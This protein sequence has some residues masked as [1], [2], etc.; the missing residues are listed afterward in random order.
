MTPTVPGHATGTAPHAA[1]AP[2]APLP[3]PPTPA[4]QLVNILGPL[5]S[6]MGA[7]QI[8][9]RLHPDD[10]GTVDATVMVRGDHIV[11]ELA[12]ANPAGRQAL[13]AALPDL[14][15]QLEAGGQQATVWM[16]GNGTGGAPGGGH[17]GP[18]FLSTAAGGPAPGETVD[19]GPVPSPAPAATRSVSSVDIRL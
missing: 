3:P 9:L 15:Q 5:R 14:R 10:L 7:H 2:A 17:P 19:A 11:V 6:A 18:G 4:A 8:S 13:T 1:P 12:A 16:S